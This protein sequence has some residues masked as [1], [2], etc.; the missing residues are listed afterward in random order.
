MKALNDEQPVILVRFLDAC[1][2][3]QWQGVLYGIEEEGIPY[4]IAQ[5]TDTDT[6]AA[7]YA[8]AQQSPLLVGIACNRH[9]MVVHFKN[10][11]P[12]SPLYRLTLAG[13]AQVDTLRSLGN[14]A[15]RLVKGLPLKPM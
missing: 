9:E 2:A 12:D 8:A 15:A 11:Q 3:G 10:L 7:A 4:Q 13:P 6:V 14:N 1:D 5:V